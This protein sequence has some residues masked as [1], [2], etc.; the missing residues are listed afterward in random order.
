MRKRYIPP[1]PIPPLAMPPLVRKTYTIEEA[2][3][4]LG[5][6][7]NRVLTLIEAKRLRTVPD[8]GKR[9]LIPVAAIDEFLGVS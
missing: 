8:I 9:V 5:V 3:E 7:R 1:P 4:V 6:G 2:A